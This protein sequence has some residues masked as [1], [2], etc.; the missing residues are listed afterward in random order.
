[1]SK[2]QFF[3]FVQVERGMT[4]KV[5]RRLVK[6]VPHVKEVSSISGKWDLLVKIVVDSREDV[7]ELINDKLAA[8]D[9]IR[10]TKTVVAYFVYN[11]DD[12]FF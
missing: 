9:G 8:I 2:Q 7:G 5:G 6:E 11:P 4:Y 10:R 3:V 1:M 12:V